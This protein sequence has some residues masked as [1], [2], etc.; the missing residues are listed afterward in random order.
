MALLMLLLVLQV[1]QELELRRMPRFW[2]VL[3]RGAGQHD[4][5]ESPSFAVEERKV[6]VRGHGEAASLHVVVLAVTKFLVLLEGAGTVA[7]IG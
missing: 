1:L 4:A 7:G 2:S 6:G 5:G 3:R